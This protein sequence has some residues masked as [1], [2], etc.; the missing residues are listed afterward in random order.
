MSKAAQAA[1]NKLV[2]GVG[3]VGFYLST[4]EQKAIETALAGKVTSAKK[5]AVKK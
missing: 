1:Y 2:E 4:E 3:N 5:A